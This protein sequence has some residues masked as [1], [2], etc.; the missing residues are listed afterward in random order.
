MIKTRVTTILG[1]RPELIRLSSI[2]DGLDKVFF[3]RII[4]TGQNVDP[5]L[6]QVFFDEL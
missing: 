3:H 2:I 5:A 4:H 1:T 6:A